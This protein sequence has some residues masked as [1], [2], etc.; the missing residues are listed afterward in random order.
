[1]VS[2]TNAWQSTATRTCGGTVAGYVCLFVT[3]GRWSFDPF[4]LQVFDFLPIAAL[5]DDKVLC[6]HGGLSPEVKTLD[7]IAYVSFLPCDYAGL[8]NSRCISFPDSG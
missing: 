6:V 8:L 5:I 7:K 3:R 1:M 4:S 2:T